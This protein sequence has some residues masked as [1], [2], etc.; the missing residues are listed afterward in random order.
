METPAPLV[1][2]KNTELLAL[3]E[4][5]AGTPLTGFSVEASRPAQGGVSESDKCLCTFI[6][7]TCQGARG[8]AT[9]FVK[10]CAWENRSE[11]VHYRHLAGCGVP[12]PLFFGALEDSGGAEVIFLETV[13]GT[14]FDSAS[15][16][17]WHAL[18]SLLAR[19]AACA[20][21]PEYAAHL[22]PFDQIGR[23]PGDVWACGWD[24]ACPPEQDIRNG[25]LV[26]DLSETYLPAL[27]RAAQGLFAEVAAQPHAL[28][29]QDLSP[30]NFGWRGERKEMVVFDL[31]KNALGPRFADVAPYL[32]SPHWPQNSARREALVRHYLDEYARFSA[33]AV[34]PATFDQETTALFWALRFSALAGLNEP[35]WA[36]LRCQIGRDLCQTFGNA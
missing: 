8:S 3:L 9:L 6:Y 26:C 35:K 28:L 14:G 20:V 4:S 27:V 29:H 18:L 33:Q 7:T 24:A 25:L 11:A 22:R 1:G 31:Q 17:E 19:F 13:T 5:V 23:L 32:A 16:T 34:S 12:V 10:R 2:L 36:D 21:T 30:D 15:E